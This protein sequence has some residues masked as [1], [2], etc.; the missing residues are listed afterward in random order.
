MTL[1]KIVFGFLVLGALCA[2][3]PETPISFSVDPETVAA[4]DGQPNILCRP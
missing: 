2:C 4:T 1:V 3:T